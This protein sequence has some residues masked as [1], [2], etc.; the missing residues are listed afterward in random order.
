MKHISTAN[1]ECDNV[2]AR[3][4]TLSYACTYRIQ[5]NRL[6]NDWKSRFLNNKD[7]TISGFV[8]CG[9]ISTQSLTV[10]TK[11]HKLNPLVVKL[12]ISP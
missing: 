3:V 11:L 2:I 6:T 1:I 7:V 10:M 9:N 5:Q 4:R 8:D 12:A